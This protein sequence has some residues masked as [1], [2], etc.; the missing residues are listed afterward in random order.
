MPLTR[1]EAAK[2]LLAAKR[3]EDS[4]EHFIK[5]MQ[6]GWDIPQFQLKLIECLHLLE[7]GELF[8]E[9]W[10][11]LEKRRYSHSSKDKRPQ[12]GDRPPIRNVLI[13]MPPRHA[14]STFGSIYFPAYFMGRDPR[15]IVMSCSYNAELA[16]DFGRKVRDVVR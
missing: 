11:A 7:Q 13:T 9:F 1:K 14:K 16:T 5:F 3:A 15:R 6:P 12:R 2:L 10:E 8:P 4:F